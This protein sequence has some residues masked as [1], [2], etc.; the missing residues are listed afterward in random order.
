MS[1]S[2]LSP[3]VLELVERD[4]VADLRIAMQ[5]AVGRVLRQRRLALGLSQA[6]V[7][8]GVC[9]GRPIVARTEAGRHELTMGTLIRYARVLQCQASDILRDAEAEVA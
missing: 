3:R 5:A 7:A 1:M 8:R 2:A 9:T 6:D 4:R